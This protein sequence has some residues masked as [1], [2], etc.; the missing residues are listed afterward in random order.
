MRFA[1]VA[2]ILL[3]GLKGIYANECPSTKS[4][5]KQSLDRLA[6]QITP[7][8]GHN[9]KYLKGPKLVPVGRYQSVLN[10]WDRCNGQASFEI[11][12]KFE[13]ILKHSKYMVRAQSKGHSG[14]SVSDKEYLLK[15]LSLNPEFVSIPKVFFG[16]HYLPKDWKSKVKECKEHNSGAICSTINRWKF[17]EFHSTLEDGSGHHRRVIVQIPYPGFQQYLLFFPDHPKHKESKLIDII[18]LQTHDLRTHLPLEKKKP[19]FF[20]RHKKGI[21]MDGGRCISCHPNGL[22][23]IKPIQGS[24]IDLHTSNLIN[25]FNQEV[26]S[27]GK[28]DW[29]GLLEESTLGPPMGKSCIQCHSTKGE[30]SPLSILTKPSLIRSKIYEHEMPRPDFF[31]SYFEQIKSIPYMKN[32]EKKKKLQSLALKYSAESDKDYRTPSEIRS[33][34]KALQKEMLAEDLITPYKYIKMSSLF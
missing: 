5:W 25:Q 2:V 12:L 29:D 6:K 8:L 27:F 33:T 3:T 4:E 22:R 31:K 13:N 32:D 18:A 23:E 19:Y 15:S 11:S 28:P 24:L 14:F 1:L 9:E 26:K 30:R 16:D 17:I 34:R 7:K 10:F 20:E 21:A